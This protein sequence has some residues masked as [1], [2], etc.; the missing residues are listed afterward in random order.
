MV[1]SAV[2][3]SHLQYCN[4]AWGDASDTAIK[5]LIS[6]QNRIIK[7]LTFAPFRS[8]NV[9]QYYD[10]LG[11]MD[12]QQIHNFEKGKFMYRLV[13]NKLPSN[14]ENLWSP[15]Q[16][17]VQYNLRSANNGLIKESFART[18]YG[19]R[20][21]QTSG[22]KLWNRIPLAI[23][24]GDTLNIFVNKYKTHI[25]FEHGNGERSTENL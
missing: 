20:R 9:Q 3:K 12:I 1:Y 19:Y 11:I 23:K 14:F 10:M 17:G 18:N 6:I 16:E 13:N 2:V 8:R 4:I 24:Q 7:I 15:I 25:L 21:I 22:A 5:P